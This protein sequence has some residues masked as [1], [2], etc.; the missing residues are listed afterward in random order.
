VVHN[1]DTVWA[2]RD[3]APAFELSETARYALEKATDKPEGSFYEL[4]TAVLLSALTFEAVLNQVGAHVWGQ[5]S[6]M[7]AAI[8]KARP[9]DKFQAIA[10]QARFRFDAGARPYQTV[11]AVMKLRNDLAHGKPEHFEADVPRAIAHDNPGFHHVPGL[12]PK[13]EQACTHEFA[14]RAVEDVEALSDALCEHIGM[15]SPIHFGGTSGYA[16]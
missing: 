16:G 4:L 12:S 3:S 13:W 11:D 14:G 15:P 8:E 9:M 7:W 10:E 5:E 1:T 2:H 6:A